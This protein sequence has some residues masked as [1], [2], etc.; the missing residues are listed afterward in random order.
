MTQKRKGTV[1]ERDLVHKFW[2]KD[3]PAVRVAG[4]GSMKYPSPD[5][6]AGNRLRKLVIEC[7]T[8]KGTKLYIPKREVKELRRF[9]EMFGAQ[10]WIAVKFDK[11]FFV[12]LED[13]NETKEFFSMNTDYVKLRGLLFEDIVKEFD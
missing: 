6:I 11:W 13:M 10:A 8:V 2:D 4:S 3:I 1:A 7:K 9:S 12:L 5:I